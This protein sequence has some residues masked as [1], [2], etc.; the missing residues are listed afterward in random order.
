MPFRSEIKSKCKPGDLVTAYCQGMEFSGE[1][2]KY[3]NQNPNDA[4]LTIRLDSG[5]EAILPVNMN[6]VIVTASPYIPDTEETG[7]GEEVQQPVNKATKT[8]KKNTKNQ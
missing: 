1:V 7:E 6:L 4:S 2:V 8:N 5:A 3:D